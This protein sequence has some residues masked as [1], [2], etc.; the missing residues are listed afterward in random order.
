MTRPSRGPRRQIQRDLG[1]FDQKFPAVF[2][3]RGL[4]ALLKHQLTVRKIARLILCPGGVSG[5][6]SGRRRRG[7]FRL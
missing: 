6:H 1:L 2:R 5:L 7:G 4:R 3:R